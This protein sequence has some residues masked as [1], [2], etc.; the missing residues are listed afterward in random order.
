MLCSIDL[1]N[2]VEISN[3]HFIQ[4]DF[5]D[6]PTKEKIATFSQNR[7]IDVVISDML[8][9][10]SG[11]KSADHYKSIDLCLNAL[12]FSSQHV[13]K[14]GSFLCKFLRG[15]DDNELIEAAKVVFNEVKIVKP[16]ASRTESSEI[17]LLA[18]RKKL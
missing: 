1:L 16:K 7:Q 17:Y 3:V 9:N 14:N 18:L 5:N 10:T 4:G 13:V 8:Q 6:P 11:I 2:I 15:S 12:E